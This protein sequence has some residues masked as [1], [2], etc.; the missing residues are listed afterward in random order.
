MNELEWLQY[1]KAREAH[2]RNPSL[3]PMPLRPWQRGTH[4]DSLP[5]EHNTQ[6]RE[7]DGRPRQRKRKLTTATSNRLPT[8]TFAGSGRRYPTAT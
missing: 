4:I 2:K 3:H 5:T 1:E 7:N 6:Y 8:K